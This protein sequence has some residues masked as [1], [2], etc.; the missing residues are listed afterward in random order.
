MPEEVLEANT[1]MPTINAYRLE[2][3]AAEKAAEE[4]KKA[5]TAPV[6]PVVADKGKVLQTGVA[7]PATENEDYH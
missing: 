1:V 2:I 6:E 3:A 4:R 7:S 5:A